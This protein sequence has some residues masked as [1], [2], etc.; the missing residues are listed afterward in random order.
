MKWVID[1]M[2]LAVLLL[3]AW[4]GYKKGLIM[5]IGA[6]LCIIVSLYGASLIANTFSYEVVSAVKPFAGGFIESVISNDVPERLGYDL[7]EYSISDVVESDPEKAYDVAKTTFQC[8]G[9]YEDT[10]ADLAEKVQTYATENVVSLKSAIV[11]V[12]CNTIVYAAAVTLCFAIILIFLT[13]VGNLPNLSFRLPN[14]E[15][16][17]EI[18]GAVVGLLR[19][20]FLCLLAVWV[21][22][23]TGLLIGEDTLSTTILGKLL[24]KIGIVSF[25]L[26]V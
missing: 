13:F 7:N 5:E 18:G 23:F 15:E 24:A 26:G 19:G 16:V 6:L 17:D 2:I 3:G 8:L 1:L 4:N 12:A 21:L 9:I 14:M 11:D 10:S 22:K 25:F 20:V